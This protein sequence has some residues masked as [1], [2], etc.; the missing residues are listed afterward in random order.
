MCIQVLQD[1]QRQYMSLKVGGSSSLLP[2]AEHPLQDLDS[3]SP[4]RPLHTGSTSAICSTPRPVSNI[5]Y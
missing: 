1:L 4:I 5:H 3:P 2:A